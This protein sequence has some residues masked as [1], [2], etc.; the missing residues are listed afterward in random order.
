MK[1]THDE[2]TFTLT[3]TYWSGT[4]PLDELPRWLDFYRRMQVTHPGVAHTYAPA[5]AAL[6]KLSQTLDQVSGIS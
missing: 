1:A 6:E 5:V 4:Y 3:G 2:T